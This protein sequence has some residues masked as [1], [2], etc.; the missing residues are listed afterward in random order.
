MDKLLRSLPPD[1]RR[2]V[3]ADIDAYIRPLDKA[4]AKWFKEKEIK[5]KEIKEK[6]STK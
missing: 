5:E 1:V 6:K 4:L 3:K 2:E